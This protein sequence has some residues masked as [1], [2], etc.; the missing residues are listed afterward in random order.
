M[1][2]RL[3]SAA[4]RISYPR[5][6]LRGVGRQ[7]CRSR[8]QAGQSTGAS[9]R[10]A[11]AESRRRAGAVPEEPDLRNRQY[12]YATPMAVAGYRQRDLPDDVREVFPAEADL[13]VTSAPE[14]DR[15]TR[16]DHRPAGPG[17]VISP[18]GPGS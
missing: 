10:A 13:D 11:R 6:W 1:G 9:A 16:R 15:R 7:Q 2:R 18:E 5:R 14:P 17:K 4:D 8:S 12:D 3:R